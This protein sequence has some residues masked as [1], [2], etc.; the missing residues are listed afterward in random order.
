MQKQQKCT[1]SGFTA[2]I[3]RMGLY[4]AQGKHFLNM[5]FSF[6]HIVF[7]FILHKENKYWRNTKVEAN[8]KDLFNLLSY[9]FNLF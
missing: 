7:Y 4:S 9:N 1:S 5:L 8:Q 2:E 3:R 6:K